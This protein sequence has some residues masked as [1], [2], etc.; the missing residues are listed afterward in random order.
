MKQHVLSGIFGHLPDFITM[1]PVVNA[2][3]AA[4]VLVGWRKYSTE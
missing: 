2:A 3:L 1:S 4:K